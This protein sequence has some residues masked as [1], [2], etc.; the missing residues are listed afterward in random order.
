MEPLTLPEQTYLLECFDYDEST[1]ILRWRIRPVHHFPTT[2]LRESAHTHAQWNATWAGKAAGKQ[3]RQKNGM[4]YI[5]IGMCGHQYLAHR[6][7]WKIRTGQDVRR[8]DHE[9]NDGMCNRFDNLRP[10]TV[11]QNNCNA[12]RWRGKVL[13]KG[14]RQSA[15]GRFEARI[16]INKVPIHLGTHDS[17]EAA[18]AA[19]CEAA[20][21][22]HGEFAN[23]GS[24]DFTD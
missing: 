15:S 21:R 23:F 5:R 13:P 18:H 12:R 22:L 20:I 2:A 17:A 14:V 8:I 16:R 24:H 7:I 1:G 19:Y 6:I 9:N 3:F 11:S 4:I 10:A